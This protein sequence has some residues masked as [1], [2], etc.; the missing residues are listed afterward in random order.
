MLC[1]TYIVEC[2]RKINIEPEAYSSE[3]ATSALG[4]WETLKYDTGSKFVSSI[5]GPQWLSFNFKRKIAIASYT[6]K[7]QSPGTDSWGLYGWYLSVSDNNSTWIKVHDKIENYDTE[8][9]YT[10]PVPI[11]TEFARID[12]NSLDSYY[13]EQIFIYYVKFFGPQGKPGKL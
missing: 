9:S 6:I 3:P 1:S 10:L 8:K 5:Y 4:A 7:T 13:P 12:G 2:L 11:I